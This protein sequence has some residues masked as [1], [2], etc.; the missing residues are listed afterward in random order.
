MNH[1]SLPLRDRLA[2]HHW[3]LDHLPLADFLRVA[4]DTGWNGVELRRSSFTKCYDAGMSNAQVL[5]LIRASG[6]KVAVIGTEYGLY[7][8]KGEERERLLKVLDETC[9]SAAALGCD[10]VMC[11]EGPR[12]G[13]LREVA[14]NLRAGGDVCKRHN[15]RLAFEFSSTAAIMNSLAVAR[16]V[17]AQIDHPSVGLLLDA[18]HLER[19]G[20]GGRGF[21]DV[22]AHEI[23]AFQYSDVPP[24]PLLPGAPPNDRLVP[25]RGVVRWREV[26]QLLD[27]K[28]FQ[29]YI[30]YESPNPANAGRQPE[31]LAREAAEATRALLV[32]VGEA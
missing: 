19:T 14:D 30:S 15:V 17:L 27:E 7:F 24:T 25:G 23:F 26:F 29:S 3:T 5:A 32:Q 31:A 13:S 28:G 2:L 8:A 12:K 21:A 11:A 6:I 16:E 1:E 9:A 4:R 22:P 10:M 20:G 18:Y